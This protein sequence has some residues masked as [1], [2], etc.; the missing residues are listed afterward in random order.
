MRAAKLKEMLKTKMVQ[1][2]DKTRTQKLLEY[3]QYFVIV[4]LDGETGEHR[5]VGK[6]E[7][8]DRWEIEKCPAN[9]CLMFLPFKSHYDFIV[10]YPVTRVR[11]GDTLVV[12]IEISDPFK[13]N[14]PVVQHG[15]YL[16]LCVTNR[17]GVQVEY[18]AAPLDGQ[19]GTHLAEVVF[20]SPGK[21]YGMVQFDG[22][23][24]QSCNA[25]LR[26]SKGKGA[27]L[28]RT[29]QKTK[30]KKKESK[31]HAPSFNPKFF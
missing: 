26:V 15:G 24:V 16:S 6:S 18:E 8:L 5:V 30:H 9:R 1:R 22:H 29:N 2:L 19:E 17:F 4:E 31:S 25:V 20:A 11:V 27:Y 23:A 10:D 7:P 21:Y 28:L 13:L 12:R 3:V 14:R